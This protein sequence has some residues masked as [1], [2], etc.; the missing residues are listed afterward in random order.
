[1][2]GW[3]NNVEVKIL[4]DTGAAISMISEKVFNRLSGIPLESMN[5]NVVG[6]CGEPMFVV[7]SV[8]LKLNHKN[9]MFSHKFCV[10]R[11]LKL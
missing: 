5:Y 2:G 8:E 10:V 3:V 4:M 9:Y 6:V 11:D 7:G 1:M